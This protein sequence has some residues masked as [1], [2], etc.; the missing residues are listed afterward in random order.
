MPAH[1]PTRRSPPLVFATPASPPAP[2][3][4]PPSASSEL[5]SR[6]A[7][8]SIHPRGSRPPSSDRARSPASSRSS[9][10]T[11]ARLG[12]LS[13]PHPAEHDHGD[14][15]HL[16]DLPPN[17]PPTRH[18]LS[19]ERRPSVLGF[20]EPAARPSSQRGR[21]RKRSFIG[22]LGFGGSSTSATGDHEAGFGRRSFL[23]RGG[24]AHLGHE[25]AAESPPGPAFGGLTPRRSADSTSFSS[26][27]PNAVAPQPRKASSGTKRLLRRAKSFGTSPVLGATK[28]GTFA[29]PPPPTSASPPIS[30]RLASSLAPPIPIPVSSTSYL[31]ATEG[32]HFPFAP[33]TLSLDGSSRASP[34]PSSYSHSGAST[35][36]T[37]HS[38]YYPP[39]RSSSSSAH[40]SASAS[41]MVLPEPVPSQ[42]HWLFAP[43]P[44]HPSTAR[45]SSEREREERARSSGEGV[46]GGRRRSADERPVSTG[47]S[48]S[49]GKE[50]ADGRS[51]SVPPAPAPK[52]KIRRATLGGLF[53]RR[54][55]KSAAAAGAAAEEARRSG[56]GAGPLGAEGSVVY[57]SPTGSPALGAFMSSGAP[58]H[59]GQG[60]DGTIPS[61]PSLP[62][63]QLSQNPYRMSWAF[64]HGSPASSPEKARTTRAESNASRGSR[65][66]LSIT[67][68]PVSSSPANASPIDENLLVAPSPASA[69]P[70]S[71]PALG[72]AQSM[73]LP[74]P[75][76][77]TKSTDSAA[78]LLI[79]N[80][81][82]SL[83][84]GSPTSPSSPA[85]VSSLPRAGL[86]ASTP[87]LRR[88]NSYAPSSS[89]SPRLPSSTLPI[90]P[91][92]L[93]SPSKEPPD[94][95]GTSSS[96][97]ASP[98]A[99]GSTSSPSLA[100]TLIQTRAARS[101]SDASD[102]RSPASPQLSSPYMGARGMVV[103]GMGIPPGGGV[104]AGAGLKVG[105]SR[106]T[107]SEG[108][109]SRGSMF[110]SLGSFFSSSSTTSVGA[111]QEQRDRAASQSMSRSSSA[112]TAA[113]SGTP[114][115]SPGLGATSAAAAGEVSE[116]GALFDGGGGDRRG[117]SALVRPGSSRKRGLSVGAGI[118]SFFSGGGSGNS[119]STSA[120]NSPSKLVVQQQQQSG[121]ARSGSASSS[122]T[123]GSAGLPLDLAASSASG[124]RV[125]ALT[126]PNRR[127]SLA[128]FGSGSGSGSGGLG[129]PG[130]AGGRPSTA[131]GAVGGGGGGTRSRGNSVTSGSPA[132]AAP[133]FARAAPKVRKAPPARIAEG[134]TP[135][136]YVRRLLE[137]EKGSGSRRP[138]R[139][140]DTDEDGGAQEVIEDAEPGEEKTGGRDPTGQEDGGSEPLPRGEV[141]RALASSSE[142]FHLAALQAFL[143]LFP[144]EN[145]AL[146]I[147]LRAFLSSASLPS[148]TQQIDRVMEA[149]ARR[150]C[151]CNPGLFGA[152]PKKR[153]VGDEGLSTEG[154][155]SDDGRSGLGPRR[156]GQEE[157][158]I[159]YVLAF[160]MVM[161]NTDQFNPNAKSK[162]TKADYVKNTR[163]D[164]VP[165]EILEYLYDQITAAPFV[166]VNDD[167]PASSPFSPSA[168]SAS[169]LGGSLGPSA[170]SAS[171]GTPSN[172]GFFGSTPSKNRLDPYHLIATGQTH[173]FKVDVES[174]IPPKSPFSYTGTT[175]FFDATKL[176][177]L[178]ARAPVLQIS[179]RPRSSSKSQA[180]QITA[181]A[182]YSPSPSAA[183]SAIPAHL[184]GAPLA[185]TVS[186]GTFVDPPKKKDRP[187]VSTLKITKVG[188]LSRK[189][190]LTE[191]G[192]K[193]ASRK[194][195]GWSVVL[196]GSQ[197]LFFKD[198]HFAGSL[199]RALQ[200][201]A[202][203]V[204]PRADD[205]EVL[206]Y[207]WQSSFKPDA[208][209]SLAHSAA[210]YDS[211]YSKY[212]NV[213]RLVAPGGRQYLFQAHDVA[214]LNSWLH[215]INYA[216]AFKTAGLRIRSTLQ[217][218]PS[219]SAS[220]RT[221]PAPAS[222][223]FSAFASVSLSKS[224][225]GHPDLPPAPSRLVRSE[226]FGSLASS[227]G[228]VSAKGSLVA[229]D[230]DLTIGPSTSS[231]GG[232]HGDTLVLPV[233][234]QQALAAYGANGADGSSAP[235]DDDVPLA[236]L[237]TP[238][239]P[240]RAFTSPSAPTTPARAD[241]LRARIKQLDAEIR[242]A[243]EALQADLRFAKHLA[244]LTPFRH[245]TRERILTALPPIE[246]RVRHARIQLAK[247]VC[248]R[249]VL[250][251]DL[252]V[253]DREAERLLRK[254]SLH[255]SHSR[256]TSSQHRPQRS[257]PVP[258]P[259]VA[260][261]PHATIK[262][263]S[264]SSALSRPSTSLH[265]DSAAQTSDAEYHLA[266]S[267]FESTADSFSNVASDAHPLS[268]T[269]DELDRLQA[270]A[271]PPLM[272][273]SKTET[274][275]ASVPVPLAPFER[276]SLVS[277]GGVQGA[278]GH[279]GLGGA[280][281]EDELEVRE[282]GAET[283]VKRRSFAL[284]S[285]AKGPVAPQRAV[286]PPDALI[287]PALEQ[288]RS[289]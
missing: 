215:A 128:S 22:G 32:N 110:G 184:A 80:P 105:Q 65:P 289:H 89:S 54:E 48:S 270:R 272:Q 159:P 103:G 180:S 122:G 165:S 44:G 235:D 73:P 213:F 156:D 170:S 169:L 116:F 202:A 240:D 39:S 255:R 133:A 194:W 109:T 281:S 69:V 112:A 29:S 257:P 46:A 231:N 95:L 187:P 267:S 256:R 121:R 6:A 132:S 177:A 55:S 11:R 75:L 276:L 4:T 160:S 192:K 27:A 124:G 174:L 114:A 210:I 23:S 178:F 14:V 284:P 245:T 176:H 225:N 98:S 236:E 140:V 82:P 53:G 263:S 94:P 246:K 52:R 198:P 193:A 15:E 237:A 154:G 117:S 232:G 171:F 38:P 207:S 143:R 58:G 123:H 258:S 186:N 135:E 47:S 28:D 138:S 242:A 56:E 106:P 205:H 200:A 201:A 220:Q 158:D 87:P 173:R 71:R 262:A 63:L 168:S 278:P 216:A 227:A 148:E 2:R 288:R 172:S 208:V 61:L 8:T 218:P 243:K 96:S 248:Y 24:G 271:P 119:L 104:F 277:D 182:P 142:P 195:R 83:P 211:T 88:A 34:I 197:L 77:P 228:S 144:F 17:A 188:L 68:T 196:T 108:T 161:L 1:S 230:E 274:D 36:L 247:L 146:D 7:H 223:R 59:D 222:P 199:Q 283:P 254:Q 234:L 81:H 238:R 70:S 67:T 91:S 141:T 147:A 217:Q 45:R 90:V 125:R 79:R 151:E 212:S 152:V 66:S 229:E 99:P 150:Y 214:E 145:L 76:Q 209:L 265:P 57:D 74:P 85:T 92:P 30:P 120:Q 13:H 26:P 285:P 204:E 149:F 179:N 166:Y 175:S 185:P 115:A 107:T 164:G 226:A 181:V 25:T 134:E 43:A 41:T 189:D 249:E 260:L 40:A 253:E 224:T 19:Q 251:R 250:S 49:K 129:P 100:R 93:S 60:E 261:S 136:A 268:L 282:G 62:S 153:E 126:D 162:M 84:A 279:G 5:H 157:S 221:T 266:R 113:S 35:P 275:W 78:T 111:A 16:A 191:G 9:S 64:G 51:E 239:P 20:V 72:S 264:R 219:L 97:T 130:V 269:D 167:E 137:G 190:D 21:D 101:H 42:P 33:S 286:G 37:P 127:F 118:G 241:L 259:H 273:R 31:A 280:E 244:V 155:A 3:P 10:P 252:L 86:N 139:V 12:S 203:A 18:E 102:R 233:S 183:G 163:I 206:V 131:D 287:P 50:R